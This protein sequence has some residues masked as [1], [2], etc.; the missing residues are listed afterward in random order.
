MIFG[1]AIAT[2]MRRA[3]PMRLH[4]RQVDLVRDVI[5]LDADQT[6]ASEDRMVI[7]L[8]EAKEAFNAMPRVGDQVFRYKIEGFQTNFQRC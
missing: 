2:G 3:E 5:H 8:P 4:W 7:L 1:L 6:K